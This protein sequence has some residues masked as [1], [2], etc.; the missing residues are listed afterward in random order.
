M[1]AGRIAGRQA[2]QLMPTDRLVLVALAVSAADFFA[3]SLAPAPLVAVLSLLVAGFGVANLYSFT[4]ALTD[5]VRIRPPTLLCR[6]CSWGP[7]WRAAWVD[8]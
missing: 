8:A 6:S 7:S 4:T 2:A 1:V 5:A 3:Y